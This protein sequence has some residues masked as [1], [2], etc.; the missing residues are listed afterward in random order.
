MHATISSCSPYTLVDSYRLFLSIEQVD[1][2]LQRVLEIN[3]TKSLLGCG[4][5]SF[6][7]RSLAEF[8]TE[9]LYLISSDLPS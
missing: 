1:A 2:R 3:T 7:G 4:E 6:E 5:R 8:P 9:M